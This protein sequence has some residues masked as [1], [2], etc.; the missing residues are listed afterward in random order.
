MVITNSTKVADV[1]EVYLK[2]WMELLLRYP[3]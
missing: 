3:R 1:K 2:K